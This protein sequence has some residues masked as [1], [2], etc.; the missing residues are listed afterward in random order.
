M[1]MDNC[2]D[3]R[4]SELFR[5]FLDN[6]KNT[7]ELKQGD[8]TAIRFGIFGEVGGIVATAK[9]L[10]RD[11][12]ALPGPREAA[13]EEFGDALWYVGALCLNRD[14]GLDQ[15]FSEVMHVINESYTFAGSA[16]PTPSARDPLLVAL[17]ARDESLLTLGKAAAD[18]LNVGEDREAEL[19]HLRAFGWAYAGALS[20]C[21]LNFEVV[22]RENI[23]KTS[24]AFG[25]PVFKNLPR[26][27][28]DY[29]AHEQLP[30]VIEIWFVEHDS[31]VSYMS[32]NGVFVGDPLTDAIEDE[33]GYRFHD[34]FHLANAAFL[35]WS[36]VTRALL[37]R[38][39]KSKKSTDR[40]QDGGRATVVEEGL[41]AWLFAKAKKLE[42]LQ[43]QNKVAYDILKTILDFVTGYEVDKVPLKQWTTA[44]LEGYAVWRQVHANQ[45]GIVTANCRDRTLT[46]QPLPPDRVSK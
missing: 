34:V 33:D 42:F 6:V 39:R 22:V 18:L 27:D 32:C 38:K 21:E 19:R 44:I 5:E 8:V 1:D 29:P 37:K 31:G 43:G 30:D 14:V 45:G 40:N 24:G 3:R 15:V 16:A 25:K 26:F 4:T 12:K 17:D 11:E 35:N 2:G 7:N 9:K 10:R 23:A 20:S 28:N 13:I 46:Y 36:P 41:T